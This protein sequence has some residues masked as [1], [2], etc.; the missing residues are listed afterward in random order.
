MGILLHK[1]VKTDDFL[2]T[3]P[4]SCPPF[5]PKNVDVDAATEWLHFTDGQDPIR[6]IN[7][8]SIPAGATASYKFSH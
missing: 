1:V 8:S 5:A 3:L 2:R 4:L 7:I 6:T